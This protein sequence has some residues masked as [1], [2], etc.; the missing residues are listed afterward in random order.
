MT[1]ANDPNAPAFVYWLY[2]SDDQLLYVGC[3]TR[4]M[5]RVTSHR[6]N[7]WGPAIA[8]VVTHQ[9]P[10]RRAAAAAEIAEIRRL[11][12][13]HNVMFTTRDNNPIRHTWRI[14]SPCAPAPT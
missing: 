1:V 4:P 11:D 14:N 5:W 3:S 10:N 6:K 2:D 12:P 13:P 8:R 9:Y 7:P